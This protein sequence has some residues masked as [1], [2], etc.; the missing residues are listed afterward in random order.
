LP[1][2]V[3]PLLRS[4]AMKHLPFFTIAKA[5]PCS[6]TDRRQLRFCDQKFT[7]NEL[8]PIS[9]LGRPIS[10]I[11]RPRRSR[12][13][14]RNAPPPVAS[15]CEAEPLDRSMMPRN[16]TG[17]AVY[18]RRAGSSRLPASMRPHGHAVTRSHRGATTP[19]QRPAR[20]HGRTGKEWL[21]PGGRR[22]TVKV[23]RDDAA[24]AV[25]A[26]SQRSGTE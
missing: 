19:A 16:G 7:C 18:A 26:L 9:P 5:A 1:F 11:S 17:L 10:P 12:R 21:C 14:R 6:V 4:P 2:A 24:V 15:F 20:S 3:N 13:S 25:D 8:R 23:S 22:P